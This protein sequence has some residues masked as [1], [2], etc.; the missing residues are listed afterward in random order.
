MLTFE[1]INYDI[2]SGISAPF[3]GVFLVGMRSKSRIGAI[4]WNILALALL[5]NIV[6]RAI[7]ATPYFFDPDSFN[8]PNVAVFNFPYV[9]LPGFVV[10]M[11]LFSHIVSFIKLFGRQEEEKY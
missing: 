10:P 9:L 8:V 7:S 2:V 4:I 3:A 5:I 11:V 6:A 1:G